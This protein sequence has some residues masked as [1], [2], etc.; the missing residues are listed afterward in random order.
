VGL[1]ADVRRG[2]PPQFENQEGM[3][4]ASRAIAIL[5]TSI[6]SGAGPAAAQ[7]FIS[8]VY[9]ASEEL[10][11][12]AKSKG[13]QSVLEEGNTI[14]TYRGIEGIEYHCDFLDVK[15]GARTPGFLITALCEEPGYAFPDVLAI[16]PRGEGQFEVTS[17]RD[18]QSSD[19]ETSGNSGTYYFC[20]GVALP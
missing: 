9:A 3:M 1:R 4:R 2:K 19:E 18:A 20:D 7:E 8:G 16:V 10:C 15:N 5:V 17:V 11:A 6:V 13:L 12:S 14:L